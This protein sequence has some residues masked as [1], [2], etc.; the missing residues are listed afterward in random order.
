MLADTIVHVKLF[1]IFR[2][3]RERERTDAYR[4]KGKR[5]RAGDGVLVTCEQHTKKETKLYLLSL[6]I[7]PE[8]W[9]RKREERMCKL[10]IQIYVILGLCVMLSSGCLTLKLKKS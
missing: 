10:F 6:C 5:E 3:E 9:Q 8:P 4:L 1:N 2:K 7:L